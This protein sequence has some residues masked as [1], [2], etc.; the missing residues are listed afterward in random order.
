MIYFKLVV[1]PQRKDTNNPPHFSNEQEDILLRIV[2][3]LLC[4]QKL[5]FSISLCEYECFFCEYKRFFCEF[6]MCSFKTFYY[7]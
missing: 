3:F 4:S 6:E 7:L 2:R 5:H 1:I